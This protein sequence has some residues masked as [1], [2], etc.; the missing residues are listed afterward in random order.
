MKLPKP[1]VSGT[2]DFDNSSVNMTTGIEDL[3]SSSVA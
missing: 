1:A 2:G 3:A